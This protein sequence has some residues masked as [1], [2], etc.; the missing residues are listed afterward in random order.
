MY[1]IQLNGVCVELEAGVLV[2]ESC[3]DVEAFFEVLTVADQKQ[4]AALDP[5]LVPFNKVTVVDDDDDGLYDSIEKGT[6]ATV[7]DPGFIKTIA[8]QVDVILVRG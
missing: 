6:I 3:A 1:Y 4:H 7:R 5:Q 8:D 2:Y